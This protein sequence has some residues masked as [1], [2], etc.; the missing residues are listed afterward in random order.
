MKKIITFQ[1]LHNWF[2]LQFKHRLTLSIVKITLL[3]GG[4]GTLNAQPN[5][6]L[7]N[8]PSWWIGLGFGGNLNYFQGSTQHIN[9]GLTAP[10]PFVEGVG[11]GLYVAPLIEYRPANSRW[12]VTLQGGFD[13]R[14]GTFKEVI[15]PCNCPRGLKTNLNYV[16]I[17]PSLRF[18]PFK[19]GLYVYAGPRI[20]YALDKSFVYSQK[21][22]PANLDQTPIED[23]TGDFDHVKKIVYSMQIGAGYD[24]RLSNKNRRSQFVLSPFVAFLPYFGQEPR[25]IETWN[26]TTFRAGAALKFGLGSRKIRKGVVVFPDLKTN[27]NKGV[28]NNFKVS[29]P[30][31]V[32]GER[33]VRE[34]FPLSNYVFFDLGSTAIPDRYILLDK[35]EVKS[36]REDQLEV[37]I[38]KRLS[39]RSNRQLIVYYN[40]LNILG[41]R[42]IRNPSATIQLIGSS[43]QGSDDG[44]LMAESVRNYLHE[45][46]G[47]E[48]A[49]MGVVGNTKPKLPSMQPYVTKEK[50]LHQE[51]D[52]RVSIESNSPGIFMEF[53]SGPDVPLKGVV[54]N[55]V[56]VAPVDSY[57]T[58][59]NP[60][61]VKKYSSWSMEIQDVK[62]ETRTFGPYNKDKISIPGNAILDLEPQGNFKVSMIGQLKN[63][64]EVR[65][66]TSVHVVLW[67]AAVDEQAMRFSILYGFNNA[68]AT[69]LYKQYLQEV[70]VPKIPMDAQVVIHGYTDKIGEDEYN[71]RLSTE[72]SKDVFDII[73]TE[74]TRVG[75]KDVR[76]KVV[77][78]G[79]DVALVPFEN[80][81]PEE[82]FYNRTVIIDI[83][84][85]E[86]KK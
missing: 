41:D 65:E 40:L 18:R 22:D 4:F 69:D 6:T 66:D 11:L 39:G 74:L 79:E 21:N 45:V 9:S 54:L 77:G 58:F 20:S 47:I 8:A 2:L 52:R 62:G 16:T 64:G 57:I 50:H 19:N 5:D 24:I 44:L 67:S 29:S 28:G 55:S 86:I 51:C 38:P 1:K 26:I 75:R 71:L 23:I 42:L 60:G 56:Q 12:G 14:A 33:K 15:S 63:G 68:T 82:R 25:T 32:V 37:H 81:T 17:E 83:I 30:V 85:Q 80:A 73:K 10:F 78:F 59:E 27:N 13:S 53:Q 61:S 36:F 34:I 7:Y 35:S 76:F 70:I 3:L 43:E 72:R 46:F 31:N 84:P 49:R 48:N